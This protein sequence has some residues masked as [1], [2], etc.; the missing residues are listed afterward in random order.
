MSL[1]LTAEKREKFGTS[2]NKII[3][4]EGKLP[5]II[6]SK[7]KNVNVTI[8][9]KEF[10]KLYFSG[11][12][13]TTKVELEIDGKKITAIAHDIATDPVTDHPIHIDFFNCSE[14]KEVRAKP[15]I[16]FAGRDKSLGIK[17]G[18]FLHKVLRRVEVL[19]ANEVP[20]E[21]VIDISKCHLGD[22]LRAENIQLPEGVRFYNKGNFLVASITGRG[23]SSED[24][25]EES[26]TPA[27]AAG[28]KSE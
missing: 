25:A 13:F 15:I 18:G 28:E 26:A 17:K 9:A 20:E 8:N 3:K 6:Y 27:A 21:V 10:N 14:S 7:D 12:A 22:K 19:C 2:A 24:S 11:K 23:K 5:A 1:V 4:K 16:N